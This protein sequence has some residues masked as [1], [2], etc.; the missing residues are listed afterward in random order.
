MAAVG[1]GSP[2]E[3]DGGDVETGTAAGGEGEVL[4]SASKPSKQKYVE[5]Q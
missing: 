1:V 2:G 5:L 4:A 3:A